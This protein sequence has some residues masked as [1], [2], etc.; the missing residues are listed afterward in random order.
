MKKI[1]LLPKKEEKPAIAKETQTNLLR[2]TIV[3]SAIFLLFFFFVFGYRLVLT[4]R[5]QES[6]KEEES[7][8]NIISS[9]KAA[10]GLYLSFLQKISLAGKILE[11]RPDFS[12]LF[13]KVYSFFPQ[14]PNPDSLGFEEGDKVLVSVKFS[15]S[16][17]VDNFL[18]PILAEPKVVETLTISGITKDKDN[19]YNLNLE[20]SGLKTE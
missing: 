10:E 19:Q 6:I 7:L 4:S 14:A 2:L 15:D 3:L 17:A 13:T 18:K 8:K 12:L 5:Y 20:F 9:K 16:Q 1:N 11:E